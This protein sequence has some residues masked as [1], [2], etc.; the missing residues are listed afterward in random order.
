M[1][2]IIWTCEE[3][4]AAC[5]GALFDPSVTCA[6]ITGIEID[7][8]NCGIG[9]LFV[10]LAGDQQDGH[11]FLA[12]A[13]DV[14]ATACLVSRPQQG[15]STTQIVV[16]DTLSGLT[17]IGAAGRNRFGGR[18]VGI[19]GSVGKT[20]SK[21]MLAH[22]LANFGKTHASQRSYNN[23][24]GVPLTL[25]NLPVDC[26]FAVQEM[27]MN[28]AGE[29]ASLTTVAKPDVAMITRVA[30]THREFFDAM[31]D[32][33]AAKAEIFQGLQNGG[34]AV[35]NLDDPFFLQLKMAATKEGAERTI[36]FG[37]H[38]EAE[39]RLLEARQHNSGM[40][41]HS[42][43]MGHE[44]TFEMQMHGSHWAQNALGVLA[45][46]DALGLDL[47][48]AASSLSTCQ[49][50]KGRGTRISGHY[51]HCA[52]TVIDDSYNASPASMNAAFASMNVMP[53]TIMIFSDMLELGE[54]TAL[55]HEM[56]IPHINA[57]SP[58]LV[59]ALGPAMHEAI[60]SLDTDIISYAAK[61]TDAASEML[62]T[63]IKDG[64]VIFI[65]GSLGS[66]SWR[67]RDAILGKLA[68]H[69]SS[70]TPTHSGENSHAA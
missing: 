24:I 19:T 29:I 7:S 49:T 15:L 65:K 5:D 2:P 38:N 50:P 67:V 14:K 37:R 30:S 1:R 46:V 6:P 11:D 62:D 58:R 22:T 23:Q 61:D 21:D 26:D 63:A 45:C 27:G 56:L 36:T 20:G 47:E 59:I 31:E 9:D 60:S 66:G 54:V 39:F 40:S 18:M 33:A 44:L 32:I 8:R 70:D 34:I 16:D 25:S 4:V 12:D 53:P 51:Q 43:I 64:D 48:I 35:L 3:L 28:S 17:R 52:V 55:E 57:L 42:E 68:I 10:A 41:V 13:A 69:P